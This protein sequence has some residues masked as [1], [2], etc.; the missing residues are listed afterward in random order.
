MV[1]VLPAPLGPTKPENFAAFNVEVE[2]VDR[3]A[4]F[5]TLGQVL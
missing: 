1:V 5:E 2:A 4:L 3:N